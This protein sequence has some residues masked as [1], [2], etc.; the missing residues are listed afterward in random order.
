MR[1]GKLMVEEV[2]EVEVLVVM[3][4]A[5]E[6]GGSKGRAEVTGGL[7]AFQDRLSPIYEG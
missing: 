4:E 3:L 1:A 5:A 7:A 6:G 2:E